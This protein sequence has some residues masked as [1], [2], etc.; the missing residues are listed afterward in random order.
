MPTERRPLYVD[1]R[2]ITDQPRAGYVEIVRRRGRSSVHNAKYW[3]VLQ[4]II[5]SGATLFPTSEH[6]HDAIKSA[7][8]YV[9]IGYLIDGTPVTR[10]DSTAFHKMKQDDFNEFY[11]RAMDLIS[12]RLIPGFDPDERQ[13]A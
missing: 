4:Q 1:P 10:P 11:R 6:L 7:L 12:T 8:G 5:D 9:E 3:A 2:A 13:A